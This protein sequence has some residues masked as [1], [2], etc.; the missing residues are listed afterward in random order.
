VHSLYIVT[1]FPLAILIT[2]L[3][4]SHTVSAAPTGIETSV[5]IVSRQVHLPKAPAGYTFIGYR[6]V[7]RGIAAAYKADGSRLTAVPASR[8]RVGEGAYIG[9]GPHDWVGDCTCYIFAKTTEW[10]TLPK[11]YLPDDQKYDN[12]EGK[13][14]RDAYIVSKHLVPTTTILFAKMLKDPEAQQMVIPP[15]YLWKG[16]HQADIKAHCLEGDPPKNIYGS[17]RYQDLGHAW[18]IHA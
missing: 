1:M 9:P 11:M 5:D 8:V 13:A 4:L 3:A 15:A 2:L 17:L 10:L 18:H 6:K 7:S 12:D 14:A 16:T